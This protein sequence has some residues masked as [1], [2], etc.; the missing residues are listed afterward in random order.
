MISSPTTVDAVYDAA[1]PAIIL[2]GRMQLRRTLALTPALSLE[3][4]EEREKF[5]SA[6]A[7]S[8]FSGSFQRG[9]GGFPLLR[10]KS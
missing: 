9:N 5:S 4:P 2:A 8:P 6:A 1:L 7:C 10:F 3:A